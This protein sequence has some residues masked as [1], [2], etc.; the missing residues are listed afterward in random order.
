M[1]HGTLAWRA[2][3]ATRAATLLHAVDV[4]AEV[5]FKRESTPSR[6]PTKLRGY[7]KMMDIAIPIRETNARASLVA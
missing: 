4:T 1:R 6:K 7:E 2:G 5:I 3:C